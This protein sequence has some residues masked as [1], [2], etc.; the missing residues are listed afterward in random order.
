MENLFLVCLVP[1]VSI[2][3][4]IDAIRNYI[5][6]EF[7]VYESLKR[8]AHI[9][10]Y[11]PVKITTL[12][13]EER[14]FNTLAFATYQDSFM[15]VLSHFG[16]FPSHTFYLNV[17]QNPGIMNLQAQIKTALKPL[18]LLPQTDHFKYTPHLTLAFKDVKPPV[19]EE[20]IKTFKDR[21]FKREF[22]VSGFSVY[23]HVN[24]RWQPYKE[25]M[26]KNPKDNPKIL[27]LFS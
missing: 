25:F 26:F 12:E 27:D 15:Q 11:N 16:S 9:T 17:V 24:K 3:E 7:N 4:D 10:L 1:P 13:M 18:K 5:S 21:K 23:K 19:F 14:F 2:V 8:P 20:I 6:E 22:L